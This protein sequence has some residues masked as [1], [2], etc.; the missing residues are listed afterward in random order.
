MQW[1][2]LIVQMY[3]EMKVTMSNIIYAGEIRMSNDNL[4]RFRRIVL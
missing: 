2:I 3:Y 4:G 1:F